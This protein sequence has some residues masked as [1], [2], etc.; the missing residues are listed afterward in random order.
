MINYNQ[1]LDRCKYVNKISASLVDDF[2]VYHAA[3]HHKLDRVFDT[4]ISR[5]KK[6]VKEMPSNWVGLIKAQFIAHQIFKER[7]LVHKYLQSAAIKS[8]NVDEQEYLRETAAYPW[9][10]CFSEIRSNPASDFYEMEDVFTGDTF[11]LYSTSV[12]RLLAEHHSLLWF[13]LIGFN[14]SCWQTFGPIIPFRSFTPDDIF[15]YATEVNPDIQ[16]DLDFLK[17]LDENPI[18]YMLLAAGSNFPLVFQNDN[19]IVHVI[20]EIDTSIPDLQTLNKTFEIENAEKVYKLSHKLWSEP[21]HYAEAYYDEISETMLLSALTDKGYQE[22][23]SL[24]NSQGIQAPFSPDIRLHIPMI[25]L[26]KTILNRD[27]DLNT[28]SKLFEV[29]PTTES[30]AHL[31]KLNQF[32]SL[33]LPFINAGQQP[34]VAKLSK[35]IGLDPE[36]ANEMLKNVTNKIKELR[37]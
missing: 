18:W 5:F 33:A 16:S 34:D 6:V 12:T 20:S 31:T 23:C 32:I 37:K 29:K 35:E 17:H 4:K 15:F 7:G 28:Y 11:L 10:M 24:L 3:I 26:I 25:Q 8:R 13:N 19:E 22:L 1:L 21:P 36:Q 30:E 27:L 14:G 9:R 2:L